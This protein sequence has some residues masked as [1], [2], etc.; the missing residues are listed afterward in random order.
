ME[1]NVQKKGETKYEVT[2][3]LDKEIIDLFYDSLIRRLGC[4]NSA[5]G[6]FIFKSMMYI[7]HSKLN[8]VPSLKS[9]YI[10]TSNYI[11]DDNPLTA[12]I[13]YERTIRYMLWNMAD[14]V[15]KSEESAILFSDVFPYY[16]PDEITVG[17]F[18]Y[19]MYA[20]GRT[21]LLYPKLQ[22]Y[23]KEILDKGIIEV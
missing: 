3:V 7:M 9:L 20:Y 23:L 12:H 18:I 21:C 14:K 8:M 2:V 17:D 5:K 19:C 11:G 4:A 1:D 6:I 22:K 13:R 16:K 10:E 15:S